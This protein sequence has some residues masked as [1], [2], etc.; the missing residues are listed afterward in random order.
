MTPREPRPAPSTRPHGGA[1]TWGPYWDAL[2]PPR[3]VTP[4]VDWKRLSTGVNVARR[5]WEQREYLRRTYESV[6]GS[7]PLAWPSPHPGV[8]LD[9]VRWVVHAAC[10]CAAAGSTRPGRT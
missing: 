7:D 6:H 2:F 5:L 1:G 9:A 8:V 3:P 4:W 10:A